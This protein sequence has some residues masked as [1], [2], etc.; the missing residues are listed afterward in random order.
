MPREGQAIDML[1]TQEHHQKGLE[2]LGKGRSMGEGQ[3]DYGE[4]TQDAWIFNFHKKDKNESRKTGQ[5][6]ALYNK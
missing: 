5:N 4:N 1:Q 3:R 2:R 6:Y